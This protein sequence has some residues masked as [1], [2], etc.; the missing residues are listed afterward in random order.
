LVLT[1][2]GGYDSNASQSGTAELTTTNAATAAQT[3]PFGSAT[4][5]LDYTAR[6]GRTTALAPYYVGAFFAPS[7]PAV[8]PLS[9]QAH[10]L[11][12]Q[13]HWSP[14][15]ALRLRSTVGT[16]LV[17]SGLN[18]VQPFTWEGV[19]GAR[20]DLATSS[21]ATTALDLTF[22][23]A[24]GLGGR[25]YLSGVGLDG[26]L[27]ERLVMGAARVTV[28]AGYRY[29]DRGAQSV[30]I[31][32]TSLFAG[33]GRRPCNNLAYV[34]PLGYQ[35]PWGR[36]TT[37]I[38]LLDRVALGAAAKVEYRRYLEPNFVRGLPNSGKT[39]E[40]VRYRLRAHTE[41]GLD[42]AEHVSVL[43]S[44]EVIVSRSNIAIDLNDAEHRFD[45]GN[46]NFV[47]HLFELGL[48]L[49]L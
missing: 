32:D 29:L 44:Y 10:E 17:L 41:I 15:R 7:A 8:Q 1:L 12:T 46:R 16:S 34:V 3:S 45:Y 26:A 36:L 2:G 37:V 47:E 13:L 4:L 49:R 30:A 38:A 28:G 23:P 33:C 42:S 6:P 35:G 22:R 19:L 20:A 25:T 27:E 21:H 14:M 31:D 48:E 43:A 24:K 5:Q 39:R 9:L 40:D 11:G 18:P